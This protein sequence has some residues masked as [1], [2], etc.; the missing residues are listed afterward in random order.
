[1]FAFLGDPRTRPAVQ[2]IDT[3]AAMVFLEGDSRAEDQ[4]RRALSLPRLFDA[5]KSARPPAR[6][7]SGS[8]GD[9]RRR[10]TGALFRSRASDDGLARNRRHRHAG[11]MG[12]RN[13]ALRR[14]A[15]ARSSRRG[16]ADSIRRLPKPLPMRSLRSH[17]M[18]PRAGASLDRLAFPRS[19]RATLRHS[20]MPAALPSDRRSHAQFAGLLCRGFAPLLEQRGAQGFV[21]RCHGDLHLANIVLIA[22]K[23]VLFDAIEFDR[24][25]AS[26][27]VL[28]DLAFPL[29]DL[30]HYGQNAAANA[31][32]QPLSCDD[33]GRTSRCARE[34][35]SVHVAAR[36]YPRPC[37]ARPAR[38]PAR[39]GG[40]R[41][42]GSLFRAGAQR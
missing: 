39:Q 37:V 40:R 9:S 34:P 5:G 22:Q 29:M 19:S 3:H 27:D 13:D 2:R 12:G 38:R 28:Y 33:A 17:D 1:M 30:I 35:P 21:R 10:S 14:A 31:A 16:R 41:Q 36:R 23:P 15:D 11:R 18:A 25:I 4:A 7:S 32:A 6:R 20:A 24:V 42:R 26:I 8:T